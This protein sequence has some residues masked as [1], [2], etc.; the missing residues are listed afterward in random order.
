MQTKL[1]RIPLFVFLLLFLVSCGGVSSNRS[2]ENFTSQQVLRGVNQERAKR[3]LQPLVPDGQLGLLAGQHASYLA[4]NVDPTRGRPRPS[5][6]HAGFKQRSRRAEK[7]GYRVVS[8]VVMIGYA[9]DLSAVAGRT[10]KG[11][12]S[13]ASHRAAILHPD[14]RVM[15][16]ETRL[17]ADGRYFVVGHFVKWTSSLNG[18]N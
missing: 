14:R 9:G 7:Q 3:G 10:I 5:A 4:R 6:A 15:G 11:W 13:S 1:L 17:P 16:V 18:M 12:L 8:E 2:A